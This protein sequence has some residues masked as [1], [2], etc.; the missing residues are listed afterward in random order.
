MSV[1]DGHHGDEAL[2]ARL[3]MGLRPLAPDE[4]RRQ[5]LLARIQQAVSAAAADGMTTLRH[6]E[7]RWQ[8]LNPLV[9]F[10]VLRVDAAAG[11]QTVLLR[12]HRGAVLPRHRHSREEEFIVLEG[13]CRIGDLRLEAG[14]AHF[15]PAGS[16]HDDITTDTGVLVLVRGEHPAPAYA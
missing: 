4:P 11:N 13:E 14:D 15:S 8:F 12:A 3:A 5:R 16:W 10:K 2:F 9:E 7:G 1:D 6:S